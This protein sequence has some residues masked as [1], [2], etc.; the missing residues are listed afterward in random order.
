MASQ[1]DLEKRLRGA[2]VHFWKTRDR[3][4]KLQGS[5]SGSRD[6]G[7]RTAVTGGRQM[8]GFISLVRDALC[9]NGFPSAHVFCE[10]SST[11]KIEKTGKNETPD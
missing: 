10:S 2:I 1:T 3:Q 11:H 7:A 8:D 4:A 6:A 9:D 5:K